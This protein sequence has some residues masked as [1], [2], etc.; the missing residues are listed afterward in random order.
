MYSHPHVI[1]IAVGRSGS[2]ILQSMLNT[3]PHTLV[4]GENNNFFYWLFKS[5][6]CLTTSEMRPRGIDSTKPWFGYEYFNPRAYIEHMRELARN[7]LLGKESPEN[8]FVLGF[9]EIRF[10]EVPQ[11]DLHPYL[12]FLELLFPGAKFVLLQR[13]P[14][15]ICQSSWWKR[16]EASL[17]IKQINDFYA[18]LLGVARTNMLRIDF[19]KIRNK[20]MNYLKLEL[21]GALEL[22]FRAKDVMACLGQEL[23]HCK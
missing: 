20:D 7:F 11:E 14:A 13:D 17:L 8:I 10:F 18:S 12:N 1:I 19:A 9:K 6:Q 5:Y 22:P 21:F 16:R 2:T 4:R 15:E 23:N 3:A